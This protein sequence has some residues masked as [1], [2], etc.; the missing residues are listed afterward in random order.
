ME[1]R[2]LHIQVSTHTLSNTTQLHGVIRWKLTS[3]MRTAL[4]WVITQRVVVVPKRRSE[5]T[6]TRYVIAK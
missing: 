2:G 6:N 1:E 5:I 4:F 3:D